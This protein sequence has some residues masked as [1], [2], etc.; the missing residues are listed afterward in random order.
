[1]M[2]WELGTADADKIRKKILHCIH[3]DSTFPENEKARDH[4]HNH[5]DPWEFADPW[6]ISAL[7]SG[8]GPKGNGKGKSIPCHNCGKVGHVARDC[9]LPRKGK[10]LKGSNPGQNAKGTLKEMARTV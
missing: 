10:S 8:K 6:G 3:L 4:H 2:T 9:R 5:S 1:M 7:H